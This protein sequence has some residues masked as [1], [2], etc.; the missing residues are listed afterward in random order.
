VRTTI[1]VGLHTSNDVSDDPANKDN[2]HPDTP[3]LDGMAL[4]VNRVLVED[5]EEDGTRGYETIKDANND[6]MNE[7]SI[8]IGHEGSQQT[9]WGES[10]KI[11]HQRGSS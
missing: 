7:V 3:A 10:T 1:G 4:A 2:G 8:V 5:L 11:Q 6:A 9:W